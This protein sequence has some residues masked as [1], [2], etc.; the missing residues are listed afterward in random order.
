MNRTTRQQQTILATIRGAGR[1]LSPA[2][3]LERGR[4]ECES[5]GIATVYRALK[6]LLEGKEIV[7]VSMPGKT[8]YFEDA[9]IAADHHHH[10]QCDDC[11]QVFDVKGCSEEL[12]RMLPPGFRMRSHDLILYG[13]CDTCGERRSG[14]RRSLRTIGP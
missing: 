13:E 11:G 8:P 7:Q 3:I 2:E 10:F 4:T 5:L 1:P 12:K 14:S 9:T 6:R